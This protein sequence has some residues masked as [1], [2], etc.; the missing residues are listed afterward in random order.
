[1]HSRLTTLAVVVLA[2]AWANPLPAADLPSAA[3]ESALQRILDGGRDSH[4]DSVLV[5]ADG[6]ELGHYYRDDKAPGPIELMSATKSVVALG[7]GQLIGQKRIESLDQ[8]V[9]DF[10]PE[11]KQGKKRDITVRMLLAHTSGLQNVAMAPTEIYPAPDVI[12][13]ALAAELSSAP[14]MGFAYNNKA[15]NLLAGIIE[16]ASGQ[17]MDQFFREGL[18]AELEVTPGPWDKDKVGNP[19]AMAGL[20]LDA[21]G[22]AKI[23]QFVLERGKWRGK[24]LIPVDYLDAMLAPGQLLDPSCGLLWW[25]RPAWMHFHFDPD[26]LAMLRKKGAAEDL[27]QMLEQALTGARFDGP[28]AMMAGLFERLGE[29]VGRFREELV[30]KYGIGPYRLFTIDQGPVAAYEAQGYL[31]Q[32]IVV[33]PSA[34]LVAVRQVASPAGDETPPVADGYLD[35]TQRVLD[36]ARAMGGLAPEPTMTGV[37]GTMKQN[38]VSLSP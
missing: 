20:A 15:T 10:Y 19:Y 32:Y 30:D 36:L 13:L 27:I 6:A 9:A 25:L 21:A 33:V 28:D 7:I 31:G 23:G 35:F 12:Q 2:L 17:P 3:A 18:F 26:S 4:S 22:A 34:R 11:W 5:L 37:S 14:G 8:P 1:M 24:Q 29:D 16:K 38:T